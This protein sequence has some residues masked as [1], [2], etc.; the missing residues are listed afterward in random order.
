[1][2]ILNSLLVSSFFLLAVP[3]YG[4]VSGNQIYG[5][6]RGS[7]GS[8][9]QE[10]GIHP[11]GITSTDSTLIVSVDI[12]LNKRADAYLVAVGLNQEELTVQACNQ[13]INDRI[14]KLKKSLKEL[15]I[16]EKDCYVD[17]ISQTKVYDYQVDDTKAKQFQRGFEIKKNII[18]KIADILKLDRLLELSA[19][20]EVYDLIK[21]EY[22]DKDVNKIYERM[23][24]EAAELI[25]LRKKMYLKSSKV[26]LT[27][28]SRVLSD[29]F[30]SVYPK[31]RYRKYEA[32]ESS[33]LKVQTKHYSNQYIRQ[34]ARKNKTFYYNGLETSGF[35]KIIN[36][37]D[38]VVGIQYVL[39][40]QMQYELDR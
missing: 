23:Y 27:G 36:G 10:T 19:E 9:V 7:S 30:Y 32:F 8:Y 26:S 20:Q 33:G 1:M 28:N 16:S 37:F 35:D 2:K 31:S 21:V 14:E 3:I 22:L 18:I 4:Q 38:P 40:L 24:E 25:E 11:R 34:E 13:K 12:L 6:S 39:S 5:N 29:N 15:G 17:F